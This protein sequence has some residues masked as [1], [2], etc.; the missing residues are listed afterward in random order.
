MVVRRGCD[1]T[2]PPVRA[3]GGQIEAECALRAHVARDRRRALGLV[4]TSRLHVF[5]VREQ[6]RVNIMLKL[7]P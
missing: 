1:G 2:S 4:R 3:A 6:S 7:K 5:R